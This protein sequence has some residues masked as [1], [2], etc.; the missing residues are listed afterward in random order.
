MTNHRKGAPE[1]VADSVNNRANTS[2][3][4]SLTAPANTTANT[5]VNSLANEEKLQGGA[6]Q[7]LPPQRGHAEAG[8][9]NGFYLPLI[10]TLM[11][12]RQNGQ[13]GRFAFT[14]VSQGEGVTSVVQSLAREMAR[15][16]GERVL[17]AA[18]GSLNRIVSSDGRE[19]EKRVVQ[20]SS[21]VWTVPGPELIGSSANSFGQSGGFHAL[22]GRFGYLL[23]D[24]PSLRRS[25]E[26]L[27]LSKLTDGVVL[28]VAAGETRKNH[29]EQARKLIKV[30]ASTLLGFVLN[31]RTYPVPDFVYKRL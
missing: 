3:N 19:L 18:S 7:S 16:T 26:A 28:V 25:S 15:H 31:K 24:C 9:G 17:I 30:S 1:A 8:P 12:A 20:V 23:I 10:Y 21:M 29:I 5:L 6:V 22:D 4:T 14:A 11:Q 2:L 13:C 27:Y